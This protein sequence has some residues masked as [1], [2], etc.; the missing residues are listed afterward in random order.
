L[1]ITL[2]IIANNQQLGDLEVLKGS[3]AMKNGQSIYL[4]IPFA[5]KSISLVS[6][7]NKIFMVEAFPALNNSAEVLDVGRL[8]TVDT[9]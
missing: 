9:Q 4:L 1:E 8:T 7:F 5:A 3:H 6:T 2:P